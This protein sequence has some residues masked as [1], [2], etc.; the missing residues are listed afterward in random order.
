MTVTGRTLAVTQTPKRMPLPRPT[1][2]PAAV[3]GMVLQRIPPQS[4][5]R[6][7]MKFP[8]DSRVGSIMSCGPGGCAAVAPEYK[9]CTLREPA[10]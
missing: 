1:Q 5:P 8:S 6:W 3:M 9:M 7:R 10:V 2:P 4:R